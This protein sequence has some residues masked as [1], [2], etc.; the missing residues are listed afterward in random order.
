MN[1]A[2][3]TMHTEMP[4]YLMALTNLGVLC[5]GFITNISGLKAMRKAAIKATTIT[6]ISDMYIS[7]IRLRK[8]QIK[9]T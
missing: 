9:F 8:K 3:R 2:E 4:I 7:P 5:S 1:I 6:M